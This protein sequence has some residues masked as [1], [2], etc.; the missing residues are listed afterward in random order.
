MRL[1]SNIESKSLNNTNKEL[2]QD[3]NNKIFASDQMFMSTNDVRK[4]LETIKL[5]RPKKTGLQ[6]TIYIESTLQDVFVY[7]VA[8]MTYFFLT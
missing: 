3:P 1:D 6:V 5:S 4:C 8:A 7:K 2:V